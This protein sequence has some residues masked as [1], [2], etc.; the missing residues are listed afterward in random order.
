[1]GKRFDARTLLV[2]LIFIQN[3]FFKY[4]NE[5]NE[6]ANFI[7][8]MRACTTIRILCIRKKSAINLKLTDK[9]KHKTDAI[10]SLAVIVGQGWHRIF[11]PNYTGEYLNTNTR[12]HSLTVYIKINYDV[13]RV[14]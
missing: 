5:T 13:A 14:A 8:Q 3:L 4:I 6:S 9:K 12:A 1:M 10:K 2:R 11:S 7:S